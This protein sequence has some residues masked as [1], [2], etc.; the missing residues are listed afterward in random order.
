MKSVICTSSLQ[1]LA[2][3]NL[4]HMDFLDDPAAIHGCLLIISCARQ[5]A[6]PNEFTNPEILMKNHHKNIH[7]FAL[8]LPAIFPATDI[9][10]CVCIVLLFETSSSSHFRMQQSNPREWSRILEA[11]FSKRRERGAK[12]SPFFIKIMIHK[13]IYI[14][15]KAFLN[16]FC[17]SQI[18]Y[19]N[20]DWFKTFMF[21]WFSQWS[22]N[23]KFRISFL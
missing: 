5:D 6:G 18:S 2:H 7:S 23:V 12:H 9:S 15:Q 13:I 19:N 20:I 10:S 16:I 14:N 11:F 4:S 1:T 3:L 17:T 21:S 22:Q 8:I